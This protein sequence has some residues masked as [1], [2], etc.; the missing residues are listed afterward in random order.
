MRSVLKKQLI[1]YCLKCGYKI[2]DYTES[3]GA[4]KIHCKRCNVSMYSL[5]K[6]PREL[7]IRVI[8]PPLNY[9]LNNQR[10]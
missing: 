4:V 9:Q 2:K 1:I 6:K 3:D 5:L 10:L 8:M 7:S